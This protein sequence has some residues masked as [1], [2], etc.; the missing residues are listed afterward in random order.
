MP[1]IRK[2]ALKILATPRLLKK[3]NMRY[4]K[5]LAALK[6]KKYHISSLKMVT[7]YP[8]ASTSSCIKTEKNN[9]KTIL[10]ILPS[11]VSRACGLQCLVIAKF[12]QRYDIAFT[13][14]RSR[15]RF[16]PGPFVIHKRPISIDVIPNNRKA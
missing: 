5:P 9:D 13:W 4:K 3:S 15:V 12:G 1:V 10:N 11:S 16:P 2:V 8:A 14:R 7:I 6:N